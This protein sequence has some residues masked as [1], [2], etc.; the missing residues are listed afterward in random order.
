[1]NSIRSL[2]GHKTILLVAHRL[3]TLQECDTIFLLEDGELID[4][5]SYQYLMGTNITF[6]RM[7]RKSIEEEAVESQRTLGKRIT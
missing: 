1:M 2:S 5:G 7:A 6:K 4:Q 3:T